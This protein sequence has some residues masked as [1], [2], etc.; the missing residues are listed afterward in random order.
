MISLWSSFPIPFFSSLDSQ[1]VDYTQDGQFFMALERI[2]VPDEDPFC[3]N[4]PWMESDL[5]W[6]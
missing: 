4:C 5:S 3:E 6:P 2:Y 1:N